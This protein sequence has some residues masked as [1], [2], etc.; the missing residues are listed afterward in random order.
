M[1]QAA[2]APLRRYLAI[3]VALIAIQATVL[4]AMGRPPICTCGT[5]RLW[6]G[7]VDSPE[8]SQQLTD[9]YTFSHIIHGILFYGLLWLVLPHAPVGL[10][11]ALAVGIEV[12]WEIVEN[13]PLIIERYRQA[14]LAQGYVG[15]SVLNSLSDTLSMVVGF[16]LAH[17][18]PAWASVVI[19]VALELFTGTMIRDS[20]TLNIIQLIAPNDTI[21][22]WQTGR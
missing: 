13:T 17:R 5:I 10:R 2:P 16:L 7:T 6:V 8:T 20:L 3:V 9:W 14:A 1:P 11:L 21:S 19:V 18:L 12:T 22:R 15:D 4:L